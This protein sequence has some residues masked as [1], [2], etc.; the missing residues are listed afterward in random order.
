[1]IEEGSQ[2]AERLASLQ[3]YSDEGHV[4]ETVNKINGIDQVDIKIPKTFVTRGGGD[5]EADDAFML[6]GN[7]KLDLP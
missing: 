3:E 4:A 1:M 6:N 2:D 7:C 5:Q